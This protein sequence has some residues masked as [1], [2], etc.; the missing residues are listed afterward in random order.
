[1]QVAYQVGQPLLHIFKLEIYIQAKY[2]KHA[3]ACSM[4]C[5]LPVC[6]LIDVPNHVLFP[7]KSVNTIK[8]SVVHQ[9]DLKD[10]RK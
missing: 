8:Y 2:L 1:M 4:V 6:W 9:S 7:T 10:L 5:T 3:N